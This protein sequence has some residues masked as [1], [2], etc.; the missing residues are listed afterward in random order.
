M[1]RF[2][3]RP[4]GSKVIFLL[5]LVMLGLWVAAPWQRTC[6]TTAPGEAICGYRFAW[7]GHD[8]GWLIGVFA[9]AVLVWELAPMTFP[10]LSMR[11]WPTAGIQAALSF[12]L[13]VVT[14]TK[15]IVDNEF[16]QIW[17]W[18][19]FGVSLVILFTAAIRVRYRWDHR[20]REQLQAHLD[21]ARA[22]AAAAKA[23][24]GTDHASHGDG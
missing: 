3:N 18:V 11:G 15:M 14:L 21:E 2:W 1:R 4:L 5:A 19:A 20:K 6:N 8:S 24:P 9:I 7:Q 16:Q 10:R 12:A 22:E 17:A 13:V 23:G